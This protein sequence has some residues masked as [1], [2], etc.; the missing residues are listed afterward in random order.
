MIRSDPI[1]TKYFDIFY[2]IT[3]QQIYDDIVYTLKMQSTK[4]KRVDVKNMK[5][6]NILDIKKQINKN[7]QAYDS[8]SNGN[9]GLLE[10]YAPNKNV[11]GIQFE[12]KARKLFKTRLEKVK[13]KVKEKE[14]NITSKKSQSSSSRKTLSR[15]S[16]KN[17]L[18]N[19]PSIDIKS[20]IDKVFEERKFTKIINNY[21]NDLKNMDINKSTWKV[22]SEIKKI[23]P[24]Y[25]LPEINPIP[26]SRN[27]S[28]RP[29]KGDEMI[30]EE[31]GKGLTVMK[32][33]QF[34]KM[35]KHLIDPF[36]TERDTSKMICFFMD[37]VGYVTHRLRQH[38]VP[39]D[40]I[41]KG[42]R[43][44]Q[45][46]AGNKKQ[47][48]NSILKKLKERNTNM[49]MMRS[50]VG[51]EFL[52]SN[53][54]FD[55]FDVDVIFKSDIEEN[56]RYAAEKLQNLFKSVGGDLLVSNEDHDKKIFKIAYHEVG[57]EGSGMTALADIGYG[58][59]DGSNTAEYFMGLTDHTFGEDGN[60][61]LFVTQTLD[62]FQREKDHMVEQNLDNP[63]ILKKALKSKI[64][65]KMISKPSTKKKKRSSREQRSTSRS[66]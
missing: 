25:F 64:L 53:L 58:L 21:K 52:E 2:G 4:Y 49:D 6:K 62:E 54:Q 61:R 57:G 36:K 44:L 31:F 3:G 51:N 16:S 50:I 20:L 18:S 35:E 8:L 37:I 34:E 45:L 55:S 5:N 19:K 63:Y 33:D 48:R 65:S 1:K 28:T 38:H 14:S 39:I 24:N 12:E 29:Y 10:Q 46:L 32:R 22:C 43:A 60:K 59:P 42:G 27:I 26:K 56:A 23:Y 40:L 47:D 41:L 13:E 30:V 15:N 66:K 9:K 7:N 17:K 11:G